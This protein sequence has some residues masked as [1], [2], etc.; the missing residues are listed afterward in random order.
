MALGSLQTLG[1]KSLDELFK[2]G[3]CAVA[4]CPPQYAESRDGA[5]IVC[6]DCRSGDDKLQCSAIAGSPA[7]QKKKSR[8]GKAFERDTRG[9][10]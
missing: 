4:F 8:W 5:F 3:D 2:P 7:K 6:R 1:G 9:E 10:G